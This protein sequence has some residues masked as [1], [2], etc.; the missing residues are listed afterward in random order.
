[1]KQ[2]SL[3]DAIDSKIAV[4]VNPESRSGSRGTLLP[5]LKRRFHSRLGT[6][7]QVSGTAEATLLAHQLVR[8]N[9]STIVAA[10]G[11]GTVNA[12]VNGVVG[13]RCRLGILPTGTAND[14]ATGLNIPR[15]LEAACTY[16]LHGTKRSIDVIRVIHWHFIT[17]GGIGLPV[18]V[19]ETVDR[20]RG[21]PACVRACARLTG[22]GLYALAML[23][24]LVHP[25]GMIA[26]VELRLADVTLDLPVYAL[27]IANV[28]TI[29][30]YMR[31]APDAFVDDGQLRVVAFGAKS[32][33]HMAAAGLRTF[34]GSH[35]RLAHVHVFSGRKLKLTT[36]RPTRFCADGELKSPAASFDIEI[37]PRAIAL[38]CP[39]QV[40]L[41][42]SR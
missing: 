24:H 6:V 1:M 29:G 4:I 42:S 30:R 31:V 34:N 28:G 32:P 41:R 10:G 8:E 35:G 25:A 33:W 14:L 18:H 23:Y 40:D 27:L 38:I 3:H 7:R 39:P 17:V 12:V 21:G 13:S 11:D 20:L 15:P 22:S 36:N 19:I 26:K 5:L 37:V 2:A 16:I 9:V